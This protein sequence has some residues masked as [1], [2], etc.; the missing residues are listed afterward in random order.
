LETFVIMNQ[1]LLPTFYEVASNAIQFAVN[2]VNNFLKNFE[3]IERELQQEITREGDY[4]L[5]LNGELVSAAEALMKPME[6]NY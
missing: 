1:H 5:C 4:F 6:E 2:P 3:Q